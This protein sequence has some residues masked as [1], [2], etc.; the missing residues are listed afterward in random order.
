ME[1]NLLQS[2]VATLTNKDWVLKAEVTENAEYE[3]CSSLL[4]LL[5]R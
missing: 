4:L 2:I 1:Q 3:C 5:F